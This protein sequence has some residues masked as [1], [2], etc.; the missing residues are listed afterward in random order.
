VINAN[1]VLSQ[2]GT[3]AMVVARFSVAM[4][5]FDGINAAGPVPT[6]FSLSPES[7]LTA[8]KNS[9]DMAHAMCQALAARLLK[10]QELSAEQAAEYIKAPKIGEH[11][12]PFLR[13]WVA[14]KQQP[15]PK[16]PRTEETTSSGMLSYRIKF[17]I[18]FIKWEMWKKGSD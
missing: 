6:W 10:T 4:E 12:K 1:P 11:Q 9:P 18:F 13:E 16:K 14:P 5:A 2:D 15:P 7:T 17:K 3:A 8:L